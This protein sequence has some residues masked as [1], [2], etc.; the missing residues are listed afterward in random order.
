MEVVTKL[1]SYGGLKL[2]DCFTKLRP[3]L[4][5]GVLVVQSYQELEGSKLL[6]IYVQCSCMAEVAIPANY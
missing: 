5:F 3:I 4:M 1:L 2:R 6:P